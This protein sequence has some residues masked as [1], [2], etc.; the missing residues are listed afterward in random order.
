MNRVRAALLAMA[1]AL[2][3]AAPGV[4]F[5]PA[6]AHAVLPDEVL[7]DPV[8]EARARE[9]S[10]GLRCLVC[11]NESIDSSNAELARD[12]RLLV[13]ERLVA[14]DTDDEVRA[15][16]VARYGDFVL[17]EPPVKPQTYL[18]WAAPGLILL[19]GIF[20]VAVYFRRRRAAGISAPPLS[21]EER[22]RLD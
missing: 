22:A 7:D 21:A 4:L 20:G 9:L 2:G 13:R 5:V 10:R 16:L 18:L 1:L 6:P 3:L 17:L 11:Q 14:G 19:A 12:L 15:Y 8:L